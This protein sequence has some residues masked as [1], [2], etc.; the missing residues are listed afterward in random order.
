MIGRDRKY[1]R[2]NFVGEF[3]SEKV[4]GSEKRENEKK[5]SQQPLFGFI[6]GPG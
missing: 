5:K 2:R 1:D 4:R 3:D 6:T